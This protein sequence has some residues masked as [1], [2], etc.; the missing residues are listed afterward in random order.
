MYDEAVDGNILD[1][2]V[3]SV[4]IGEETI[5]PS[6]T[7]PVG[8]RLITS[9]V[10]PVGEDRAISLIPKP[11]RLIKSTEE[12][13]LNEQTKII[14]AAGTMNEAEY[15]AEIL[16]VSTGYPFPISTDFSSQD[17]AI[18]LTI[19]DALDASLSVEGYTLKS[20]AQNVLLEAKAPKGLFWECKL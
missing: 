11:V 2:T 17:N 4:K 16:R 6:V 10:T 1:A 5:T 20:T 8:R 18:I 7:S 13:T 14:T 12:F 19:S 3:L 15:L 9:E